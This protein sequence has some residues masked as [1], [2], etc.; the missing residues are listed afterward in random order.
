MPTMHLDA[1]AF[2]RP[3]RLEGV[4]PPVVYTLVGGSLREGLLVYI[5]VAPDPRSG[6]SPR[7]HELPRCLG[8]ETVASPRGLVTVTCD[9]PRSRKIAVTYPRPGGDILC[10]ATWVTAN[11]GDADDPRWRPIIAA[12]D[13]ACLSLT[14]R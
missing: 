7:H 1:P 9:E 12:T 13:A 6:R 2:V 10:M 14:F 11:D 8:T 3:S 4:D 5:T